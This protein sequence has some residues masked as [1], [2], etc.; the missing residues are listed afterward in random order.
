MNN[1]LYHFAKTD[2]E[3]LTIHYLDSNQN[4]KIVPFPNTNTTGRIIG[5]MPYI[6]SYCP[7][8]KNEDC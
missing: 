1:I 6:Q 4:W 2:E 7:N 5:V 3:K 8:T